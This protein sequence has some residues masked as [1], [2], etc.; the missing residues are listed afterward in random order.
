V[1]S[2]AGI[3]SFDKGRE[4]NR[5]VSVSHKIVFDHVVENH[6]QQAGRESLAS[7]MGKRVPCLSHGCNTYGKEREGHR[8]VL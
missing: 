5:N 8:V 2:F 7:L 1:F 6:L 4:E 3:V